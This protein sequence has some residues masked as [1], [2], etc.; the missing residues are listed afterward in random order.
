MLT[1]LFPA[2]VQEVINDRTNR[3]TFEEIKDNLQKLDDT[4]NKN[5]NDLTISEYQEARST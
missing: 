3:S 2:A 1:K 5:I 4:L